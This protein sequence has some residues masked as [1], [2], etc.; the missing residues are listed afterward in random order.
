[1]AVRST[2]SADLTQFAGRDLAV[3]IPDDWVSAGGVKER[4]GLTQSLAAQLMV[5]ELAGDPLIMAE[6]ESEVIRAVQSPWVLRAGTRLLMPRLGLDLLAR[7][8]Y[9]DA[10][11]GPYINVRLGPGA[12][13]TRADDERRYLGIHRVFSPQERYDAAT[14]WWY[15]TRIEEWIGAPFVASIAGFVTLAGR[16]DGV[17]THP[18]MDRVSFH[19]DTGDAPVKAAFSRR[20]IPIHRG[21]PALKINAS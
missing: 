13:V 2:L 9:A 4:L 17:F 3:A 14:R 7:L 18:S 19:V 6:G 15:F 16:I 8:P 5:S 12:R 21:G 20:R 1:M 11:V 10:D